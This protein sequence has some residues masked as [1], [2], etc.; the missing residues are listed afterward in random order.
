LFFYLLNKPSTAVE[1]GFQS[2]YGNI[3]H[4]EWLLDGSLIIGFAAGYLVVASTDLNQMSKEKVCADL[5]A[6]SLKAFSVCHPRH[7]VACIGNKSVKIIDI[8]DWKLVFEFEI[9]EEDTMLESVK[10]SCDSRSVI[11]GSQSGCIYVFDVPLSS[12]ELVESGNPQPSILIFRFFHQFTYFVSF[13]L[14]YS[15]MMTIICYLLGTTS[16][17]LFQAL[18]GNHVQI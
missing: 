9:T 15:L 11:I 3:I 8:R 6:D 5:T 18:F 13:F 10:W 12:I 16:R 1:L 7:K 17:V 14:V 2:A 4:Y